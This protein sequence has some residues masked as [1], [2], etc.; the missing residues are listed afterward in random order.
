M[1]LHWGL[2]DQLSSFLSKYHDLGLYFLRLVVGFIFAYH[3]VQKLVA[4][5]GL[6]VM[7]GGAEFMAPAFLLGFIETASGLGLMLGYGVRA[8][9]MA[10]ALVAAGGLMLKEMFWKVPFA[11][12]NTTGWEFD[13]VL[14]AANLVILFSGGGGT[15]GIRNLLRR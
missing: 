13:L 15:F 12:F 11:A 8:A 2:N 9:S 14:L 10:L 5:E 1:N 6:A 7:L 4:P 3:G